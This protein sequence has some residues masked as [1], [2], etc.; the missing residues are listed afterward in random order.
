[1]PREITALNANVTMVSEPV[2][3][4]VSFIGGAADSKH[5]RI[6]AA[7]RALQQYDI[8]EVRLGSAPPPMLRKIRQIIF[9]AAPHG[10]SLNQNV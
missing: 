10:V 6:V 3:C 7:I 8:G 4:C 1:M 9:S 2:R 5:V